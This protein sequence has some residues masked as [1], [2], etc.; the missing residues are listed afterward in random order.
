MTEAEIASEIIQL[1]PSW[2]QAKC[3]P[4]RYSL[5]IGD[6][7]EPFHYHSTLSPNLETFLKRDSLLPRTKLTHNV[8]P[9]HRAS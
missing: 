3:G 1:V 7:E 5:R 9:S 6:H 4:H 2:Y 8:F